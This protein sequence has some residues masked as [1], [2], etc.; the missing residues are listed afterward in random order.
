MAIIRPGRELLCSCCGSVFFTWTGYKDQD[1]DKGFGVCQRC[2]GLI[3]ADEQR[4]RDKLV[5]T[6]RN[7]L[8]DSNRAKFDSYDSE[9][10]YALAREALDDGLIKYEVKRGK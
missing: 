2:Q 6:L 1:R 8:N 10:Q 9:T 4:E 3:S 5:S 7:A